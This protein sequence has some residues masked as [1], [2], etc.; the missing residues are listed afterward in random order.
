MVLWQWL[1]LPILAQWNW[2]KSKDKPCHI[3]PIHRRASASSI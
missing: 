3:R 1:A 2:N